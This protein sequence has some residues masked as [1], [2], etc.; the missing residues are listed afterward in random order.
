MRLEFDFLV[1]EQLFASSPIYIHPIHR[2]NKNPLL[3]RCRKAMETLRSKLDQKVNVFASFMAPVP[4]TEFGMHDYFINVKRPTDLSTC[5]RQLVRGMF[6]NESSFLDQ[7]LLIFEN[8]RSYHS[9]HS[10]D[11]MVEQSNLANEKWDQIWQKVI[12]D[13]SELLVSIVLFIS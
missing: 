10:S 13:Y 9:S 4:P 7:I 11:F 5:K 1:E 12:K 6:L 8:S 3:F 2:V